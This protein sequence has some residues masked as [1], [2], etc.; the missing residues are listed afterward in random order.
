MFILEPYSCHSFS[1]PDVYSLG[2]GGGSR[3]HIKAATEDTTE[4]V[5]VGPE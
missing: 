4:V 2:L 5:T 3:I 1:M